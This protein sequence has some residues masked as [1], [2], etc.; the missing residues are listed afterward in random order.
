MLVGL[1]R[2]V[3]AVSNVAPD[4]RQ[5]HGVHRVQV[6]RV[7]VGHVR[8]CSMELAFDHI[9]GAA[10]PEPKVGHLTRFGIIPY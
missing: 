2:V 9:K 7:K 3:A 8:A 10:F 4:G 1:S 6:H 5:Y